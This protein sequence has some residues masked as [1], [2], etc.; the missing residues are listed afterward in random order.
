MSI[1]SI[2]SVLNMAI[3]I[4]IG[5][6]QGPQDVAGGRIPSLSGMTSEDWCEYSENLATCPNAV[7]ETGCTLTYNQYEDWE[8]LTVLTTKDLLFGD[9]DDRAWDFGQ[10]LPILVIDGP[11]DD[12]EGKTTADDTDCQESC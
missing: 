9:C 11:C 3:A 5:L 2:V 12:G 1:R 8:Y 4:L 6:C 10:T 7:G